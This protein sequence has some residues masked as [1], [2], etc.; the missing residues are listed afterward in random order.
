MSVTE[1]FMCMSLFLYAHPLELILVKH[2][3]SAKGSSEC[4]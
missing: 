2:L 4:S 3:T 1:L